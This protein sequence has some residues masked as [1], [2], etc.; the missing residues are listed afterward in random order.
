M[1]WPVEHRRTVPVGRARPVISISTEQTGA[2]QS[3]G[4][5]S[6]TLLRRSSQPRH[7]EGA[8][9][10]AW[11]AER[12]AGEV[13]TEGPDKLPRIFPPEFSPHKFFLTESRWLTPDDRNC[14]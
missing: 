2:N 7:I 12:P 13:G 4:R 5:S 8:A 3:R 10:Q 9:I 14:R 11:V 1:G 6:G